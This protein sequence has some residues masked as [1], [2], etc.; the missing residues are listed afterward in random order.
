MNAPRKCELESNWLETY[1]K[2]LR[3][4]SVRWNITHYPYSITGWS[5]GLM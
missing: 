5:K 4:L 3:G 1:L 2:I